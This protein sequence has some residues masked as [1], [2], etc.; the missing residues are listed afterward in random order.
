MIPIKKYVILF[1]GKS[2]FLEKNPNL[3]IL[4]H[5]LRRRAFFSF[6]FCS[7]TKRSFSSPNAGSGGN[8][9]ISFCI[10]KSSVII[11]II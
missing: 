7:L 3:R 6:S 5:F 8:S 9:I 4:L 2:Y 1:G 11:T 10:F